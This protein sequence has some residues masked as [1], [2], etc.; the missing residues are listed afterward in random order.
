MLKAPSPFAVRILIGVAFFLFGFF[1]IASA[2]DLSVRDMMI[3]LIAGVVGGI[4]M[5]VVA[6]GNSMS[7]PQSLKVRLFGA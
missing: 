5:L 1:V 7:L 2:L 6:V 3:G 4:T